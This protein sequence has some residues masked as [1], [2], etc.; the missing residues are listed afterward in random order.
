MT[1]PDRLWIWWTKGEELLEA[2]VTAHERPQAPASECMGIPPFCDEAEYIRKGAF[3]VEEIRKRLSG[4][5]ISASDI[6][7][8]SRI[9]SLLEG[10][11]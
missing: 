8:L 6:S 9:L 10:E 11:Q 5:D 7:L 3:P 4:P 2:E 1:A